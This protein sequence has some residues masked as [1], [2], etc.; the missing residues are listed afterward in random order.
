MQALQHAGL[1]KGANPDGYG[2]LDKTRVGVLV[3][4]GM[5]GLTGV[6]GGSGGRV[7]CRWP[8]AWTAWLLLPA[9]SPAH[10][11]AYSGNVGH[12]LNMRRHG[13][14]GMEDAAGDSGVRW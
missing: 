5:G 14:C 3:G 11:P 12:E 4:S 8:A 10:L 6:Q 1:E 13:S 2:A 9:C 7:G